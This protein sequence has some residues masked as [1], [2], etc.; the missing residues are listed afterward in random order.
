LAYVR[1]GDPKIR[2]KRLRERREPRDPRTLEEFKEQ[3]RSEE[4]QFEIGRA[5]KQADVVIRNDAGLKALHRHIQ[6]SPLWEWLCPSD[7][8]GT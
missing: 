1:V 5:I 2:F 4:A 8:P 3:E 7:A 6:R